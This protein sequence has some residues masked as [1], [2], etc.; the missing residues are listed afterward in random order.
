[1]SFP[2]GRLVKHVQIFLAL[3]III[4]VLSVSSAAQGNETATPQLPLAGTSRPAN[5]PAGFV[6]T[7]FGYF[8]SRAL[9]SSSRANTCYPTTAFNMLTAPLKPALPPAPTLTSLRRG[10]L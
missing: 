9:K 1:M 5:V 6:I 8:H 7:P 3:P 2:S 10:G 4:A